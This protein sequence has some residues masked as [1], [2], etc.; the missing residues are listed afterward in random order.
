MFDLKDANVDI[1]I[2]SILSK[3]TEEQ[4]WSK[5]CSNFEQIDKSFCSDLYN[6]RNPGCRIYYNQSNKLV[7]KDFGTG[8]S[9][10]CFSYIQAKY[11][12]TFKESL[13]IIYND[14]KLGSIK[15]DI[16]PQLVLNNAPEVLKMSPKSIIEIVKQPFNLTDF[17]YWNQ[18]EIPL[19]LLEEYNVFSCSKV[20]L[21]KNGNT[22]E[23]IANKTNP[24]YA[25]QFCFDGK[26]SY[27]IY[28]PLHPDKKRK[29]LFS[30]GSV[31]DI[32]GYDQLPYFEDTL[33]L[34][35]SLKDCMVLNLCGLPAISLQ[36]ETNKLK[37]ELVNKL[38]K[39]FNNIVVLYDNDQE[40]IKGSKRLNQQ[41]G[42][43][44]IFVDEEKDIS[45]FTYKYGLQEAKQMINKKI[46]E[47]Y[48]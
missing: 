42:F 31:D 14:F 8:E 16:I 38:L 10:D 46:K 27:K 19:E 45:D 47:L 21:H 20:Y 23:F 44:Y 12:C 18:Y 39:R 41:Y 2:E 32:E 9:H 15:Y 43:K 35:K 37:Q 7:Y 30:G 6:D 28:F 22:I 5:Y 40:G 48:G 1:T 29:W 24:I 25:Y 26:Y 34:T 4:L 33:I 11:H 17:N 36:G 13:R 3:I